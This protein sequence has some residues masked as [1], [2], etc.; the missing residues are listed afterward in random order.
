MTE[1]EMMTLIINSRAWQDEVQPVCEALDRARPSKGPKPLYTSEELESALVYQQLCGLRCYREA[2]DRLAGDRG[3]EVR[4][5]LG[6]DRPRSLR[7][8][9]VV[10]LR[11]GVPSEPTISR[12]LS[13]FDPRERSAM[14]RRLFEHNVRDHFE[15]PE[16]REEMRVLAVD[17]THIVTHFTAPIYKKRTAAEK[18][19]AELEPHKT[20]AELCAIKESGIVNGKKQ[21]I[22][23][24]DGG[25]LPYDKETDKSGG[26]GFNLVVF[27]TATGLPA[28][29]AVTPMQ[30]SE[31][32]VAE[33]I[34]LERFVPNV[35]PY[36]D[37]KKLHLLTADSAFTSPTLRS[38][39]HDLGILENI[40]MHSHNTGAK[41]EALIE[42]ES[43]FDILVEGKPKWKANGL[44]EIRCNCGNGIV[45]SRVGRTHGGRAY[46]R[47]EG[48][49]KTCGSIT[50][51]AGQ[52]RLAQ[53]PKKF[54]LV[55]PT[56]AVTDRDWTFGN[57]LTYRSPVA[58][59]FGKKR[60]GHNE[61]FHGALERR[62]RLIKG[63]R[64]YRTRVEAETDAAIIFSIM[65]VLAME[66]RRRKSIAVSDA[67]IAA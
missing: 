22:T 66:Q 7:G 60:F 67:Q 8:R 25:F 32:R 46:A 59:A 57:P 47:V 6:F 4:T 63:K 50:I 48:R 55:Q 19:Q 28:E 23:C 33:A 24:P 13:L 18:R 15:F 34:L 17:G 3:T 26:H 41:T 49:C 58:A 39:L 45:S 65:H 52:W 16:F 2:R 61:G 12:H 37:P 56:D 30:A 21:K 64:W 62:F 35:L 1:A 44:R 11:C 36:L 10:A 51:T 43:K 42:K 31:K 53:N 14:Y 5:A 27:P 54:R 9:R 38:L 20:L 40:H 29:F